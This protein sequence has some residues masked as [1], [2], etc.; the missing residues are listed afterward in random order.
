MNHL[1]QHC[2][3][4][5]WCE[6][7]MA[8]EKII[9]ISAVLNLLSQASAAH[10]KQ[11]TDALLLLWQQPR[12]CFLLS[13]FLSNNKFFRGLFTEILFMPHPIYMLTLLSAALGMGPPHAVGRPFGRCQWL[14]RLNR[15]WAKHLPEQGRAERVCQLTGLSRTLA[16]I[17]QH[18]LLQ[19]RGN[20]CAWEQRGLQ[21]PYIGWKE[22]A[23][24][25]SWAQLLPT[26]RADRAL[27]DTERR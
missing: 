13:T 14:E 19:H 27:P 10:K 12:Y 22:V 18:R 17:P 8:T 5:L 16:L 24:K 26:T 15:K 6:A 23:A 25:N 9:P 4:F 3:I 2:L 11:S 20:K 1:Q 21:L 7:S